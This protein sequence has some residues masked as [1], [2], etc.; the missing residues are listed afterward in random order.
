MLSA[1]IG[2]LRTMM[3]EWMTLL[4]PNRSSKR[5][6]ESKVTTESGKQIRN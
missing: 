3:P 1:V 4:R 2:A 6:K 5:R